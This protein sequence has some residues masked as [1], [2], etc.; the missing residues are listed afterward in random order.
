M[1]APPP[2]SRPVQRLDRE[3]AT[4][5]AR[6][7]VYCLLRVM[8]GGAVLFLNLISL[9]LCRAALLGAKQT[10]NQCFQSLRLSV[11]RGFSRQVPRVGSCT[12]SLQKLRGFGAREGG[13]SML[14]TA[15]RR[16]IRSQS[17]VTV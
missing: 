5:Q 6:T 14:E 4:P 12:G 15:L 9:R 2:W 7:G 3:Q 16:S 17:F 8:L 11:G 13:V 1:A 10:K